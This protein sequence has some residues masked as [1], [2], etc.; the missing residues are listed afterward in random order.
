MCCMYK[1]D[2][3]TFHNIAFHISTAFPVLRK[4]QHGHQGLYQN[5]VRRWV[6]DKA[7]LSMKLI[8]SYSSDKT[9]STHQIQTCA[10]HMWAL[11]Q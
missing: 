7:S 5:A 11:M 9:V 3:F 6:S 8:S 2:E 4:F 10:A 1:P